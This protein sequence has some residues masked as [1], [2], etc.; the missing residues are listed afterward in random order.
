[1]Q[2]ACRILVPIDGSALSR[3]ALEVAS[4]LARE[5]DAELVILRVVPLGAQMYGPPS[6]SCLQHLFDE[7]QRIM[8]SDSKIRVRHL[9]G[10]GTPACSILQ[11]ARECDCGLIVMGT[12]GRTGIS[13][14]VNGSVTEEVVRKAPCPVLTLKSGDSSRFVDA[15]ADCREAI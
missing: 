10:E 9:L 11:T 15:T 7:L 12:H 4:S 2:R 1:M 14:F 8:P 13:R 5:R 6:E 3:Q